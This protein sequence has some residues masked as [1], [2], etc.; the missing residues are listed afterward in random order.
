MKKIKATFIGQNG[1][2]KLITDKEYEITIDSNNWIIIHDKN[3]D[4]F[5]PYASILAF[6]KNWNN[7]KS[8]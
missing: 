6:F 3:N 2:M 8:I 1:S 5:C 4:I 7:I